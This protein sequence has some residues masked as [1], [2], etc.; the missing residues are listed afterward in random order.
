MANSDYK[1]I[2][3]TGPDCVGKTT[4]GILMQKAIQPSKLLAFPDNNHWS[5]RIIRAILAEQPIT[6]ETPDG[7]RTEHTIPKDAVPFQY[8]Q[9][10]SRL[11]WKKRISGGLR[12][13]HW[14]MARY[15]AD[16][17]AYG[18]A[19]GTPLDLTMHMIAQDIPSDV[20]ILLDGRGFER[21]GVQ[22][23]NDRNQPFQKRVREIYLA[24]AQIWTDRFIVIDVDRFSRHDSIAKNLFDIHREM[25][26]QLHRRIGQIV[27]PLEYDELLDLM[28]ELRPGGDTQPVLPGTRG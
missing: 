25:C 15:D 20:V 28:P 1:I 6:I 19:E 13:H 5:G 11:D 16:A 4:H 27:N 14:I 22:D 2:N 18:C 24:Q 7:R 8:L 23:L 17:I 10:M 3:I 9:A 21:K 12:S 26:Y